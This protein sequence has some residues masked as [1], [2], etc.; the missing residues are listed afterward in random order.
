MHHLTMPMIQICVEKGRD[1][2][3]GAL[4]PLQASPIPMGRL[5]KEEPDY[6]GVSSNGFY[7]ALVSWSENQGLL[8]S[9]ALVPENSANKI[10]VLDTHE[11]T[12]D[13]HAA[14]FRFAMP[15]RGCHVVG[16]PFARHPREILW[17]K[18]C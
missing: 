2:L 5:Y 6:H 14:G 3:R 10:L 12:P 9:L 1:L 15:D 13:R 7:M 4:K 8:P 11:G 16:W 18:L 17:D